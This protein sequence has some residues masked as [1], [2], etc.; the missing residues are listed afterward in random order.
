[1]TGFAAPRMRPG[2]CWTR[3][4]GLALETTVHRLYDEGL[5]A[6]DWAGHGARLLTSDRLSTLS[7]AGQGGVLRLDV[8]LLLLLPADVRAWPAPAALTGHR[9]NVFRS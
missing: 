4:N 1:M 5:I 3:R 9:L 7:L 2:R 8:G 6:F